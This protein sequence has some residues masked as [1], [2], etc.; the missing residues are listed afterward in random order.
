MTKTLGR[1]ITPWVAA[2]LVALMMVVVGPGVSAGSTDSAHGATKHSGSGD[3]QR[4]GKNSHHHEKQKPR[5]T[6]PAARFVILHNSSPEGKKMAADV[7]AK[8]GSIVL[9]P[10]DGRVVFSF[11][12]D[13]A[14]N[15]GCQISGYLKLSGGRELGF[16]AAHLQHATL[17][18][19]GTTF[20]KG[21]TIGKIA[22]WEQEPPNS[23]HVHWS[24]KSPGD[25]IPPK[26]NIPVLHAFG[27][28]GPAPR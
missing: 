12:P 16:V 23:T 28:L 17:P 8:A 22:L 13:G 4:G 1:R 24:F 11:C 27:M 20:R 21:Q 5:D 26:A 19:K 3:G 2:S 9:A 25:G 10:A 15:P 14:G 7:F 18:E 6:V